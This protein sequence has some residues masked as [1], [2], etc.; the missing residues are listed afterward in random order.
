[1]HASNEQEGLF[2]ATVI[3][4]LRR[5]QVLFL[6]QPISEHSALFLSVHPEYPAVVSAALVRVHHSKLD[7]RPSEYL[8][9]HF[10][11][12]HSPHYFGK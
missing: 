11:P 12:L 3:A 10:C 5:Y 9:P 2:L 4:P 7:P 6:F 8:R 1:M